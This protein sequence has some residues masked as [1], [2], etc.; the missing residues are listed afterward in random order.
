MKTLNTGLKKLIAVSVSLPFFVLGFGCASSKSL[1]CFDDF[2][3]GVKVLP[4]GGL[5]FIIF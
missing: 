3:A 1:V 5:D 2:K 4:K